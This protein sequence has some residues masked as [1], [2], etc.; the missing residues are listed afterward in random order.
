MRHFQLQHHNRDYDGE[1]SVAECFES[2][3]VHKGVD[4][5]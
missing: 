1:H 3:F 2:S 5:L 4:I